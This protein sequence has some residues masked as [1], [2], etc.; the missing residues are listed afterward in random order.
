MWIILGYIMQEVMT[1]MKSVVSSQDIIRR[2]STS[3]AVGSKYV[4]F[5]E[6]MKSMIDSYQYEKVLFDTVVRMHTDDLFHMQRLKS[7]G[8]VGR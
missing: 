8:Q 2:V 5:K 4:E 3:D 1:Q 6:M 7:T